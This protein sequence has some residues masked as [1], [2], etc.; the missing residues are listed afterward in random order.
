MR[1]ILFHLGVALLLATTTVKADVREGLVSYWPL[2]AVDV[3][4]P[5][6]W[7]YITPD[8]AYTNHMTLNNIWDSSVLIPGKFGTA[9]FFDPSTPSIEPLLSFTSPPGVDTGLPIS[10]GP[11]WTVALWVKGN[12]TTTAPYNNADR[13]VF[14]E[15]SST[16]NDPLTSLGTRGGTGATN[17]SSRVFIRNTPAPLVQL[18]NST[19]TAALAFDDTWRHLALVAEPGKITYYVDGQLDLTN[20][21][22]R[23]PRDVSI[24]SIGGILRATP[25]CWFLGAID[26]VAVWA[27]ALSQAE[28][29]AVMNNSIQLP[30]PNFAPAIA[31]DPAGSTTVGQGDAWNMNAGVYGTR[32][33]SY[34]WYKDGAPVA[35]ATTTALNLVNLMPADA[36]GYAL[37]AMN[38][39]GSATSAVAQI[40]VAAPDLTNSM[41]AYWPLDTIVGTK[42]PD[43]VSGYDMTLVNLSAANLVPGRFGSCFEFDANA[44]RALSRVCTP[45]E[46]LP[47]YNE[48]AFSISMWV[49][50]D[51]SIQQDRRVYSEGSTGNNNPLFNIGTDNRTLAGG[52]TSFVDSFIRTD[53]G[54]TANHLYGSLPTF[55]GQWRHIAY[56][57]SIVGGAPQANIYIDGVLDTVQPSP[58][59]PMTVNTVSIGAVLR[60]GYAAHF[61]GLIDEVAIWNRRLSAAEI[62]LL[63]T[64]TITNPPVRT[65]PLAISQFRADF[66]GVVAGQQVVLRWDVSSDASEV[67]ITPGVGDVTASTVAGAG[68][69]AVTIN[70]TTDFVL[71][72]TRGLDSLS[73]TTRVAAV[74]GVA[75]GWVL[76]DN[77][78]TYPEGFL[79][80]SSE[81][82]I[83]VRGRVIQVQSLNG[84]RVI[85]MAGIADSAATLSLATHQLL[86]NQAGTL[87]FRIIPQTTAGD[88]RH[89]VG[90]TDVPVRWSGDGADNIGPALSTSRITDNWFFGARDGITGNGATLVYDDNP[91]AIGAVYNVWI[92][93]T[94]VSM[95]VWPYHDIYSVHIQKE[96][97]A[98]RTTL[99]DGFLS[100]RDKDIVKDPV[101]PVMA[102]ELDK[103]FVTGN[104][105]ADSALLDDFYLSHGAYLA[106]VPAPFNL[107]TPPNVTITRSGDEIILGWD[108]GTLV[109]SDSPMGPWEPVPGATPP[110]HTVTPSD[111]QKYYRARQ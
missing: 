63:Q 59:Y 80:D 55:D 27:R 78:E 38:A 48:P 68:S 77:F 70:A 99:F 9:M 110:S 45:E 32:P 76:L 83:D 20:A 10:R 12:A 60:S 73:A 85:N 62:A 34:Q 53:T 82:F 36:G 87:F 40:S 33:L 103:L 75:P 89:I 23:G 105:V 79:A 7:P 4:P 16:D 58:Q 66:P 19:N 101:L 98:T 18:E 52:R 86:E 24:T 5:W 17:Y 51:Y 90:L 46:D 97:E 11:T 22:P 100:D 81:T 109:E 21:Y 67:V 37:V 61:T 43:L 39:Y 3:N 88:V 14:C 13:R 95:A 107:G 57:Q 47:I 44:S 2:D 111:S 64:V 42:T 50:G 25:C 26:D 69:R 93:I 1:K 31:V 104:S 28:I 102:P 56:V 29:Q 106:T 94:N 49:K 30:I 108:R 96:G 41:I 84:N 35:G 91:L 6:V 54:A 8:M 65:Q 72:V 71:T 74:E 92:D 15:S